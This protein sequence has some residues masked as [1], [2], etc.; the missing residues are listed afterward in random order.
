MDTICRSCGH[1][2]VF[3]DTM[4]C[5]DCDFAYHAGMEEQSFI[6]S[7]MIAR[8]LN[9]PMSDPWAKV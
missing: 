1:Y 5:E 4:L 2:S 8:S 6:R 3:V 7:N 9:L